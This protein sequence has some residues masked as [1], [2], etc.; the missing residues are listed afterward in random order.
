MEQDVAKAFFDVA[1]LIRAQQE[2]INY[3]RSMVAAL[4]DFVAE[5]SDDPD[6]VL[7]AFQKVAENSQSV[8]ENAKAM[9]GIDAMSQIL[10]AGK[11]PDKSDA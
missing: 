8:G 7:E 5:R 3:L 6:A 10:R 9:Q 11:H 2:R 4:V 1:E